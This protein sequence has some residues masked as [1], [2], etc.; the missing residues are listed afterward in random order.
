MNPG[1]N[2]QG[3]QALFEA[4]KEAT[5]IVDQ[6]RKY[7]VEKLKEARLEANKEVE[8]LQQEKNNQIKQVQLSSSELAKLENVMQS[9]VDSKI[10]NIDELYSAN[11]SKAID[12]V[13]KATTDF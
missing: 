4:E 2:S 3:I 11:K 13:L 12:L 10:K 1:S 9:E 8:R 5:K 7:R 6:A